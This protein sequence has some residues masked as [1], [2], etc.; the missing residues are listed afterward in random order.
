M[1]VARRLI[2]GMSYAAST[3]LFDRTKSECNLPRFTA[4]VVD[5]REPVATRFTTPRITKRETNNSASTTADVTIV[6][7]ASV[8]CLWSAAIHEGAGQKPDDSETRKWRRRQ[9]G[10]SADGIAYVAH[11]LAMGN[12]T[13]IYS[14]GQGR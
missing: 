5:I 8:T 2:L 4:H 7:D 10:R 9:G 14:R 11:K 1:K 3:I 13:D 6:L 12:L